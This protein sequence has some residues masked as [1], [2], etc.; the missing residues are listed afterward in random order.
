LIR[1]PPLE[2]PSVIK[3]DKGIFTTPTQFSNIHNITLLSDGRGNENLKLMDFATSKGDFFHLL[4]PPVSNGFYQSN[5]A[6]LSAPL[7]H[8]AHKFRPNYFAERSANVLQ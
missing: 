6:E 3:S 1:S 7:C 8:G 5:M 4:L 2:L